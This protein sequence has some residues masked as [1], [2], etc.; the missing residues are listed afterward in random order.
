MATKSSTS[1]ATSG[2]FD[3]NDSAVMME[4]YLTNPPTITERLISSQTTTNSSKAIAEK[5]R[6]TKEYL[7][8]WQAL[9][10]ATK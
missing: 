4:R 6:Q 3:S 2:A 10:E 1:V 5:E 8:Q 7:D 9:W